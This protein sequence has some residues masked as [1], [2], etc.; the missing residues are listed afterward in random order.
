[1]RTL[2]H[3]QGA[4]RGAPTIRDDLGQPARLSARSP[5]PSPHPEGTRGEGEAE[6]EAVAWLMLSY[7]VEYALVLFYSVVILGQMVKGITVTVSLHDV[8]Y[9]VSVGIIAT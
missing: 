7:R 3:Q 2:R 1:M 5:A 4:V 8:N 9:D 6:T